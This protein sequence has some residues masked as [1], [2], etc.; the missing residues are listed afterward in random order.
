MGTRSKAARAAKSH[1]LL[2][3]GFRFYKTHRLYQKNETIK[4]VRIWKGERKELKLGVGKDLY[5][6]IAKR[7]YKDLKI[8]TVVDKNILA[9]V[10]IGDKY[11]NITVTLDNKLI[12]S[13]PLI[14][15][16]N[17]EI[18]SIFQR[19]YDHLLQLIK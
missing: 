10:K 11:G 1:S 3:Y 7:Y 12:S 15:L 17:L 18:G 16:E 4:A 8:E 2:N 6:T 19:F 9:P 14:A 13:V 5:V